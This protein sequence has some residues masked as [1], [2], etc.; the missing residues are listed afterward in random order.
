MAEEGGESHAKV[1]IVAGP[2]GNQRD[3]VSR[4]GTLWKK[5]YTNHRCY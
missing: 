2:E 3:H 4:L 1:I 5:D